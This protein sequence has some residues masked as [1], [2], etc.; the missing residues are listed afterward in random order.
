MADSK[1]GFS[2]SNSDVSGVTISQGDHSQ[3]VQGDD[4]QIIVGD[5][6]R[7]GATDSLSQPDVVSLL[8]EIEGLIAQA[9]LPAEVKDEAATYAKAAKKSAEK[10]EPKKDAI[11]TNLQSMGETITEASKTVDAAKGL[12]QTV[13]PIAAKVGTW[14]GIAALFG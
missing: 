12:W 8:A 13:L 9:D 4:N 6:N 11:K 14:L 3:V 7:V 1:P 10:D 2:I 5:N